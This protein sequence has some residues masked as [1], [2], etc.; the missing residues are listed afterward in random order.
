MHTLTY[1]LTI[2]WA[3][4]LH[5]Y[6]TNTHPQKKKRKKKPPTQESNS[7][8]TAAPRHATTENTHKLWE[9]AGRAGFWFLGDEIGNLGRGLE[10]KLCRMIP[11]IDMSNIPTSLS[12]ICLTLS[13]LAMS[14]ADPWP[15]SWTSPHCN[16]IPFK[17][18][19]V[20]L[21]ALGTNSLSNREKVE[22]WE[23]LED[24]RSGSAWFGWPDGSSVRH[25]EDPDTNV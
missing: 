14:I 24:S 22:Q 8:L 17:F 7:P 25:G 23:R 4:A 6:E 21:T 5:K 13:R 10:W 20:L 12:E 2:R 15:F 1:L 9:E 19:P 3:L 11:S 16:K 18:I